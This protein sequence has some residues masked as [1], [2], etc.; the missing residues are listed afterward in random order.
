MK[1]FSLSFAIKLALGTVAAV[2]LFGVQPRDASAMTDYSSMWTYYDANGHY[3][4]QSGLP[5]DG[6][7][8][9]YRGT[10]AIKYMIHSAGACAH[11]T[12]PSETCFEAETGISTTGQVETQYDE[13]NCADIE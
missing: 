6:G 9:S 2:A 13:I 7:I 3:L 11:A 1:P 10:G 5:C 8:V 12:A 4:G